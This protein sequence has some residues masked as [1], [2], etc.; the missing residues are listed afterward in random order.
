MIFRTWP[1][2]RPYAGTSFLAAVLD[3][4]HASPTAQAQ[5]LLNTAGKKKTSK[6]YPAPPTDSLAT[7]GSADRDAVAPS[8]G[9]LRSAR[10]D[11]PARS[12]TSRCRLC[13]QRLL[14]PR[15][16]DLNAHEDYGRRLLKRG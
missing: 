11:D 14:V 3:A 2:A 1:V 7:G 8:C 13:A 15:C 4:E 9:S 16:L 12:Q 10:V 6:P 5:P